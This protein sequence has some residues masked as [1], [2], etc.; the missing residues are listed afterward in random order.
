MEKLNDFT[1][2]YSKAIIAVFTVVCIALG[3]GL[4][5]IE[6]AFDIEKTMGSDVPYV[7]DV[8]T[9]G[10]SELGALYSYDLVME[11]Q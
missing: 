4:W 8:M 1:F 5:K 9:V 10:R 3:I 11:F 6:P 7:K 2:K